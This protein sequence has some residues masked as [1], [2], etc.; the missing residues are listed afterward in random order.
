[1]ECEWV[2]QLR[3]GL[4][5][6]HYQQARRSGTLWQYVDVDAMSDDLVDVVNWAF[7]FE[8]GL[9]TYG[10]SEFIEGNWE[11]YLDLDWKGKRPDSMGYGGG[12]FC[13]ECGDDRSLN[14]RE[15]L[16]RGL[17]SICYDNAKH[18]DRLFL[19]PTA[20]F[21]K[22]PKGVIYQLLTKHFELVREV[23]EKFWGVEIVRNN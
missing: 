22:N 23:G 12:N 3:R 13:Y 9:L 8:Y 16:I 1:M 6:A 21:T 10:L 4:C 14:E 7:E 2:G 19:Y 20:M 5:P 17:C 18:N 11:A 15:I